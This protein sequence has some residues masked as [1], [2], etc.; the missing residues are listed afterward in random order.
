MKVQRHILELEERKRV[1]W[2]T[3]QA[4]VDQRDAH[5]ASDMCVEIQALDRA[6]AELHRA[7][8]ESGEI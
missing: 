5:G 4:F 1:L 7:E 3:V 2:A 6:I 8:A